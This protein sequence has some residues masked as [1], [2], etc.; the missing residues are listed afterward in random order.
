MIRPMPQARIQ[1]Y[2][3][4][5]LANQAS[6]C[7]PSLD[8]A[9]ARLRDLVALYAEVRGD[10]A[11]PMR[12]DFSARRL[13]PH[14]RNLTFVDRVVEPG[15]PRRYRFRYFGSGMAR[16]SADHTGKFLD[17]VVPEPFLANWNESWDMPLELAMPLRY[18]TRFQSLQIEYIAM[19]SFNGP[20]CDEAGTPCALLVS[21]EALPAVIATPAAAAR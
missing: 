12:A 19:E 16:Y 8:F 15:R 18:V 17:E 11:M 1:R 6:L 4:M 21:S 2:N 20:L 14:L 10:R 9:N 13:A 7:D 5:G 3:K